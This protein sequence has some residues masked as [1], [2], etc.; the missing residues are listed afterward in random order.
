MTSSRGTHLVVQH[1]QDSATDAH[2]PWPL[3]LETIRLLCG[4]R[5]VPLQNHNNYLTEDEERSTINYRWV[6]Y[7]WK[8][9]SIFTEC[10]TFME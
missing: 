10:N 1:E 9:Y 5:P 2:I 7:G 8:I 6:Y 3:H 4:G